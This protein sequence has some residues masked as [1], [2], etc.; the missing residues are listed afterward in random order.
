M[1]AY[2]KD[3]NLTQPMSPAL[4]HDPNSLTSNRDQEQSIYGLASHQFANG[5][6]YSLRYYIQDENKQ[7]GTKPRVS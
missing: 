2:A 5:Q 6:R 7:S 3:L 4:T 1:A